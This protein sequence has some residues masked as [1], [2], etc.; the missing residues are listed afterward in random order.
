M[1]YFLVHSD[2]RRQLTNE[3]CLDQVADYSA[4]YNSLRTMWMMF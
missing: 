1:D 4:S 3:L 2:R